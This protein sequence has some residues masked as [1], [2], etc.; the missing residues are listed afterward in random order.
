MATARMEGKDLIVEA[1]ISDIEAIAAE[2]VK[3]FDQYKDE[4]AMIY[5]KMPKFDYKYFCFYAYATYTLLEN[6]LKFSS[7]EAGHF[8]LKAPD[9]FYYMFFGMITTLHKKIEA[10]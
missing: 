7:A 4:I 2:A 6:A 9:E 1:D 3:N 5:D 8:R 10:S